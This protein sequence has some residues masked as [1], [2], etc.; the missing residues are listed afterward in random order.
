[1]WVIR[2]EVL[3]TFAIIIGLIECDAHGTRTVRVEQ[4]ANGRSFGIRTE[5]DSDCTQEYR[6]AHA[7]NYK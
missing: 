2:E 4:H 5:P 1:M 6:L 3:E 7:I